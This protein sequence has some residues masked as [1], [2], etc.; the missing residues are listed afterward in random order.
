M[1]TLRL[2]KK[3]C[4][5]NMDILIVMRRLRAY[6]AG[7]KFL[8]DQKTLQNISNVVNLKTVST[9]TDKFLDQKGYKKTRN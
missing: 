4:R 9:V 5:R 2:V 3:D 7:L 6:G 1:N 8:L